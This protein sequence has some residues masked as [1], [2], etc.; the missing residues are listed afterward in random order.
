MFY[1]GS[2]DIQGLQS[3]TVRAAE[4][5]LPVSPSLRE[6]LNTTENLNY[7]PV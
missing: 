4:G 5:M 7:I 3:C 1:F 6:V 2:L